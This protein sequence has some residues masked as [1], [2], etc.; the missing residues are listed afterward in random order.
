MGKGNAFELKIA[1]DDFP[2]KPTRRQIAG[3]SSQTASA[4]AK[5][6]RRLV[7]HGLALQNTA[8]TLACQNVNCIACTCH[9]DIYPKR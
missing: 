2:R 5:W 6:Q 3:Q 8:G 9:L 1:S 4:F 7:G